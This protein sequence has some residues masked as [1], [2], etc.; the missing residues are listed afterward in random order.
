[1]IQTMK[2]TAF[3]TAILTSHFDDVVSLFEDL[4]F[5]RHHHDETKEGLASDNVRLKDANG[6]YI[7]ITRTDHFAQDKTLIRMNVD[8]FEEGCRFLQ[9]Y[10]FHNALGEGVVIE[11]EH[12]KGVHMVSPSG[13]EIMMMKH[14]RK[15]DDIG[16]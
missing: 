4:G 3:N 9:D 5:E 11:A 1:M 6:Y 13:F 14:I 16:L 12:W 10:G 2:L 7:D 8:D 15:S